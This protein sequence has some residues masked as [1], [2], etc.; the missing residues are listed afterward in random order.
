MRAGLESAHCPHLNLHGALSGALSHTRT[1][2]PSRSEAPH[3]ITRNLQWRD[4]DPTSTRASVLR[5]VRLGS[6]WTAGIERGDAGSHSLGD[7]DV[8]VNS[9][10]LVVPG[11]CLLD[12]SC[13]DDGGHRHSG[14]G[15][16]KAETRRPCSSAVEQ[17]AELPVPLSLSGPLRLVRVPACGQCD[18]KRNDASRLK[19]PSLPV[20]AVT[21]VKA[22]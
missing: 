18:E 5:G 19:S 12:S 1:L 8:T 15:R 10:L 14:C 20:S 13:A 7:S 4:L 6:A 22:P 21:C 16:V 2:A 3:F 11:S 9:A 17:A